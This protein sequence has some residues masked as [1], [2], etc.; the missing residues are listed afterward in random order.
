MRV[1]LTFI[2]PGP[3]KNTLPLNY[4]YEFSSWIYRTIHNSNSEFG[5]WLHEQGYREGNKRFKL[6]TFS[7]LFIFPRWKRVEDRIVILSGKAEMQVSFYL[8]QAVEHFIVGL[9]RNQEF[10]VGD[11]AARA[12]FIVQTVETLPEPEF[13]EETEFRCL[14]P[15]CLSQTVP[16]KDHPQYLS[17]RSAD[18]ELYFFDN[19]LHKYIAAHNALGLNTTAGALKEQ[20]G[21]RQPMRLKIMGEPRSKLVKIKAGTPQETFVKGFAY[22]FKLMAPPELL[23]FGYHAGFGEKNSMGFGCVEVIG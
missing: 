7:N 9:F 11:R 2:I 3:Q 23:R 14:S 5:D 10:S 8:E 1:R 6:F 4:Q 16:G 19:L 20:M 21:W 18:Y 17:P 13:K 22:R 15:I 12:H